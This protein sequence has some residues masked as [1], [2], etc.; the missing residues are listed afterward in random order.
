VNLTG[1]EKQALAVKPTNNPEAYDLYLRGL[2]FEARST[3][4]WEAAGFYE[5]AVQLD[6]NFALA[7][8]RLSRADADIYLDQRDTTPGRRN[9]AKRALENAQKLQ[10]NSSETLLALGYYQFRVL[11]DYTAAKTTF[12]R[13]SKMLPA[14]T[15]VPYALAQVARREGHW[16]QS[17]AYFEQALALDPRNVE[18]LIDAA[19]TYSMVRQFPAALRLFDRVLDVVPNE[20][21]AMVA[22]ASIYQ[23]Q[24]NLQEAAR[25]LSGIDGQ[26]PNWDEWVIKIIQLRLERNYGEA[27]RVLQARLAQFHYASEFEKGCEQETL[28]STQHLAGDTAGAKLTAEQARNTLELVCKNQPD[29]AFA[30]VSLA[31]ANAVI[32][33]RDLA[34]KQM[35]R[36][37]TVLSGVGDPMIGPTLEA[38]VA[39]IQ[40]MLGET[41]RPISTFARLLQTPGFYTYG[42]PITPA[43]LRLDPALDPL[44]ADP[45]FQKLCEEKQPP[46]TP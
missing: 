5:R 20:P 9:A 43:L 22:K 30:W 29:N 31:E 6:P 11:R 14:S 19:L 46:A 8:A 40:T 42:A 44:R 3:S 21:E 10:P 18:L 1:R 45:A 2:S 16:D 17:I 32:G 27:I 12:D 25:F 7:W 34:L 35:I 24:G 39:H 26:T 15:E 37:M 13:V 28:A 38:Y 33:D 41:G 4:L 23:A 36:S